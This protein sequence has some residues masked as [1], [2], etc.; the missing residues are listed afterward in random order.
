MMNKQ[1]SIF[2]APQVISSHCASH[3]VSA[4]FQTMAASLGIRQNFSHP[5][6]HQANGR[7]EMAGQQVQE[8][9]RK[10]NAEMGINWVEALLTVLSKIHDAPG[11]LGLSPYQIVFGRER[12]LPNI[13]YQPPHDCED[14]RNF[15][16]RV[17]EIDERVARILNE[18]HEKLAERVNLRRASSTI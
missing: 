10:L 11:E 16:Q 4:W 5:Y 13:P 1:W 17:K 18:K 14:A 3:F 9:L 2:C 15:F 12:T 6:H 8:I 7:V